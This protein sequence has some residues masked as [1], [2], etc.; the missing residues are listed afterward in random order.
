[1]VTDQASEIAR[2]ALAGGQFYAEV[3]GPAFRT[4]DVGLLHPGNSNTF[5]AVV[6]RL[7]FAP[8]H[9]LVKHRSQLSAPPTEASHPLE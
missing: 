5:I 7:R 6:L 8:G 2:S 9:P 4:G 1:M 3:A